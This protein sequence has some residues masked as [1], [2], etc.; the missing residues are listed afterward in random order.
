MKA[1][2]LISTFLLAMNAQAYSPEGTTVTGT[3]ST[4]TGKDP[5]A[6]NDDA[7]ASDYCYPY[8]NEEYTPA[9]T[10]DPYASNGGQCGTGDFTEVEELFKIK[11]N[12]SASDIDTFNRN[13]QNSGKDGFLTQWLEK[14]GE[15]SRK[16]LDQA[17]TFDTYDA[18][19]APSNF[20]I[21]YGTPPAGVDISGTGAFIGYG[22][23]NSV[24]I[25]ADKAPLYTV[26]PPSDSNLS[27]GDY[28]GLAINTNTGKTIILVVNEYAT[29]AEELED[30]V[31]HEAYHAAT[32]SMIQE[33]KQEKQQTGFSNTEEGRYKKD[34]L[35][36]LLSLQDGRGN[37]GDA[38][39]AVN[40]TFTDDYYNHPYE[41]MAACSQTNNQCGNYPI[42]LEQEMRNK[43]M[44]QAD[45]DEAL[46]EIKT[47]PARERMMGVLN[48]TAEF[49]Q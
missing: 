37:T 16:L 27:S 29:T 21:T 25:K 32:N 36:I 41:Y 43:G 6:S 38:S 23:S 28:A 45:I 48:K 35:D 11:P 30:T 39:D 31:E 7:N 47:D 12:P 15:T 44:S 46:N 1:L 34:A 19:S 22:V 4:A 9:D 20:E 13:A 42:I 10:Y 33:L 40:V 17:C 3:T 2:V 18:N 14:L 49:M 24:Y 8:C 26:A 5:N